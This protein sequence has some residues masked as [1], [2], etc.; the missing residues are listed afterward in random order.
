MSYQQG[1]FINYKQNAEEIV[2]DNIN[3]LDCYLN[4]F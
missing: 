4:N 1:E 2:L 3:L